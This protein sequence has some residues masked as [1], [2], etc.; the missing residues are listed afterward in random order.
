MSERLYFDWNATTPLRPEARAAGWQPWTSSAIHPRF[1]PKGEQR[2]ILWK[3]A[4]DNVA[5]LVGCRAAQRC[6]HFRG[7]E[8]NMLALTPAAAAG[9]IARESFWSPPS[10]TRRSW[11]AAVFL[12]PPSSICRLP[13]TG[14]STWMCW[15]AGLPGSIA[16]SWFRSCLPTMRPVLFNRS[17]KRLRWCT[18]SAACCMSTRFRLPAECAVISKCSG[19]VSSDTVRAQDWG[20][21]RNWRPGQKGCRHS[22]SGGA[23]ERRWSGAWCSGRN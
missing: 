8:A 16:R 11:Q 4:R 20:A 5:S 9:E 19:Q 21:E 17:C 15:R 23:P 1:M 14:R 10:S 22:V 12:R 6:I 18:A 3:S 7:T 2:A 13:G